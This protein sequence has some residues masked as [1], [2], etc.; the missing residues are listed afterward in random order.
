MVWVLDLTLA[1]LEQRHLDLHQQ[2]PPPSSTLSGFRTGSNFV[3]FFLGAIMAYLELMELQTQ[4]D[5]L[6]TSSKRQKIAIIA[7]AGVGV[8]FAVKPHGI[9]TCKGW[10]VVDK[11]GMVR[12]NAVTGADGTATV[13]LFDKDDKV[14]ISAGVAASGSAGVGLND[15]NEKVRIGATTNFDGSA[16]VIWA[17]K[18]EKVRI[19]AGVSA[20]GTVELPT[21]DLKSK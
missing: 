12:I 13:G 7:L 18:D 10:Q 6:K 4:I 2:V 14:R 1:S 8:F 11:D 15:K 16:S 3:S 21:K 5:E 20:N 9:I 19:S 17:D